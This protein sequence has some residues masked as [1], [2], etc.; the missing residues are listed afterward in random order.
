MNKRV[1]IIILKRILVNLQMNFILSSKTL[2]KNVLINRIVYHLY[3][4]VIH[5]SWGVEQTHANFHLEVFVI[6]RLIVLTT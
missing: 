6:Q 2:I 5:M 1:E 4:D 3:S